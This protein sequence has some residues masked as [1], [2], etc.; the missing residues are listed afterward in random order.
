MSCLIFDGPDFGTQLL[1][2]DDDFQFVPFSQGFS[3]SFYGNTYAGVY[4]N[5][6]GNLTFNAGDTNFVENFGNFINDNN[7]RIAP[8]WDDFNPATGGGVFVQQFPD[9]FIVT[10][11]NVPEFFATGSNTFQVVLFSS[12]LIGFG[13]EQ[14]DSNDGLV[15]V[16]SGNGGPS[17]IFRYDPPANFDPQETV[18]GPEGQ[19][20][21]TQLFWIYNG[22]DYILIDRIVAFCCT[23][24][25]PSGFELDPTRNAEVALNTSDECLTCVLE[26]F[27][28]PAS[29]PDPCNCGN[30][31]CMV[32]V[33]AVRGIGNIEMRGAVPIRGI[34]NL[35]TSY[36]CCSHAVCF[37]KI[38]CLECIDGTNPCDDPEFFANASVQSVNISDLIAETCNGDKIYEL[39]GTIRLLPCC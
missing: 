11:L 27:M 38:L 15:G 37:N 21:N 5:S 20:D 16:A 22:T 14:L 25:V 32:E 7:P 24:V 17:S 29:I 4:V 10:W 19:L 31:I 30:Q 6:N 13:Y 12:G 39:T 33:N 3:F 36:V 28:V 26:P 35:T 23:V 8:I 1:L 2:G 34:D 9:R 18:D